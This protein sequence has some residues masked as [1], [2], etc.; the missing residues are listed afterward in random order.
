MNRY[1]ME[2]LPQP[3][4]AS[5]AL[6]NTRSGAGVEACGFTRPSDPEPRKRRGVRFTKPKPPRRRP[7]HD[8]RHAKESPFPE[9]PR[10]PF[11][12]YCHDS[13]TQT[14]HVLVRYGWQGGPRD[15]LTGYRGR[16]DQMRREH[17][18]GNSYREIAQAFGVK[19]ASTVG[20]ALKE[21]AK[22]EVDVS[23]AIR[24]KMACSPAAEAE[25]WPVLRTDSD[26]PKKPLSDAMAG[27]WKAG[28]TWR[29]G[30]YVVESGARQCMTDCVTDDSIKP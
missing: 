22:R 6:S 3:T 27:W 29:N 18:G 30:W 11:V 14:A 10:G 1:D 24:A 25:F 23:E 28:K 21:S 4:E 7:R 12:E 13:D 9:P 26:T 20:R 5:Q 8:P 15:R 2:T 16:N 19:A 17:D